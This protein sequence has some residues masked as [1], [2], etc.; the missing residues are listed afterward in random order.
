MP[1]IKSAKKQMRQNVKHRLRNYRVRDELK[2]TL[3]GVLSTIKDDTKSDAEKVLKQ[4]YKV[5]DT[6]AK[7]NILHP[8]TAA[9]KKSNMARLVAQMSAKTTEA[10]P[11]KTK[12]ASKA[13]SKKSSPIESDEAAQG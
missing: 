6:A 1:L 7:K 11:A 3:K 8:N 9:H 2:F 5:I 10:A 12:T 4:A 13:A